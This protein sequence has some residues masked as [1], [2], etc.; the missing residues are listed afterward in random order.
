MFVLTTPEALASNAIRHEH[1]QANLINTPLGVA[2]D[3]P[4]TAAPTEWIFPH[5]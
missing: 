1:K 2:C 4:L 3:L 5:L